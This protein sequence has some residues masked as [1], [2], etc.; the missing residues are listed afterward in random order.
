MLCEQTIGVMITASHNPVEDNGLKMVDGDGGMLAQSW[1]QVR[2]VD[3]RSHGFAN[4][5]PHGLP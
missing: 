4:K 5:M 2:E 1:E 3:T